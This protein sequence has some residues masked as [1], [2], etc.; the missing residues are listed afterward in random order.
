MP[1]VICLGELLIDF[2]AAEMDTGLAGATRFTKAAGGAPANVAVGVRRLGESCGFIGAVGND[3]FG[4]FLRSTVQAED[5]DTSQMVLID[6]IRTSLAFIAAR[7]DGMKDITFYRNPGADMLLSAEHLDA[8]Y[9][10]SAEAFHFGSISRIDELPREATDTARR[11]AEN[12][13]AMISYDPNWRPTL[14]GDRTAARRHIL[15]AFDCAHIAKVSD[16]E[17]EFITGSGEF[18]TGARKLLDFGVH[19]VVRSEGPAGASFATPKTTGH[20]DGFEVGC[21]EPTGAGDGAMAALIVEL[22]KHWRTGITPADLDNR[23]LTRILR[24]ANAVG[25]LACKKTGAIPSLPT[26]EE[27]EKFQREV[28]GKG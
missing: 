19:L 13:G 10:R 8:D 28:A 4:H 20:V 17:W 7:S 16:E 2:C 25:A 1:N 23:E 14:W 6:D 22:L 21:I 11:I 24:Q 3:P 5:V 27:V 9:L 18:D 15:E 26:L 12:N